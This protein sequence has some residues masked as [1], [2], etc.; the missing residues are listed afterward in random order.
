MPI[1]DCLLPWLEAAT[2]DYLVAYRGRPIDDIKSAWRRTRARAV[3]PADFIPYVLRHTLATELRGRGVPEW[4][5]AGWLGHRTAYRTT[6]IYAKYRP[7][8]LSQA[9]VAIDAWMKEI[10]A[11]VEQRPGQSET[12]VRVWNVLGLSPRPAKTLKVV[13]ATGIEPVTPTMST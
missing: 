5:C 7:E 12:P 2:G 11:L 1:T 4:E 3:L 10:G 9:R 13:G 8:F 6:E